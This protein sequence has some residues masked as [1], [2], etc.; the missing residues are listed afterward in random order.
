MNTLCKLT[1]ILCIA[2]PLS[3]FAQKIKVVSGN[4]EFLKDQKDVN[5]EFDYREMTFYNENISESEY[6]KRR[7]KEIG[8]N[9][10]EAES[11]RWRED[12]EDCKNRV[13]VNKFLT[14]VN[15]NPRLKFDKNPNAKYTLIVQTEWIYPGWFAAVMAQ[16]AKVSTQLRFVETK[17]RSKSLL[18]ISSDK[19]PGD[20]AFVG[21]PN[22]NDRMAE[23]YAKTGKTLGKLLE[24][25]V[26]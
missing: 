8:D 21:V 1:L 16:K 24:R 20:I 14:L 19:A 4:F 18:V 23:G 26:K 10:G 22:N 5:V 25:N 11:K 13:F 9:K 12:W 15:E 3:T 17:D 2:A 6:V 7:E